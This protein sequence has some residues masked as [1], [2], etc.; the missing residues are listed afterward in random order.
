MLY[1]YAGIGSRETPAHICHLM[2]KMSEILRKRNWTLYSGGAAGAD[3][4][5]E[6]GAGDNK[7]I[8]L[9]WDGFNGKRVDNTWY[10]VPEYARDTAWSYV[11]KFH[12]KPSALTEKGRLFMIRNTYQVL[13]PTLDKPVD[14]VLCWTKDGKDVGG[15][16]Q[17]IRIARD[18]KIPV[19]NFYDKLQVKNWLIEQNLVKT[20]LASFY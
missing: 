15:T 20:N 4:A 13:G 2:T 6:D 18:Y 10:F 14:V 19:I 9:P 11:E 1:T 16:S 3:Q 8:F 17:A 7:W 12:P 5:F